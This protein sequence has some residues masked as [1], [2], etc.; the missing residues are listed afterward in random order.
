MGNILFGCACF[1]AFRLF[2][3]SEVAWLMLVDTTV[4]MDTNRT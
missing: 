1:A 4:A 3:C 2:F